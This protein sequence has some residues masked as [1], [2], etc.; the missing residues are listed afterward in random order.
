[1]A[2]LLLRMAS[3]PVALAVTRGWRVASTK[4]PVANF[5]FLVTAAWAA[6]VTQ[7]SG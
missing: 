2:R 5:S 7:Q 6:M 3:V 4:M 1:M